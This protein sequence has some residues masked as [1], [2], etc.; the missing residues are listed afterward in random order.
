MA[1][2]TA[3]WAVELKDL[4][5]P[6]ASSGTRALEELR[7]KIDQDTKALRGLQAAQQR[8]KVASLTNAS[9]YTRL[10]NQI[11]AKRA[12][13]GRAEIAFADL[14]GTFD[15]TTDKAA[16][17]TGAST[18]LLD[19]LKGMPG[20]LGSVVSRMQALAGGGGLFALGAAGAIAVAT[21]L[22]A[23]A[24]AAATATARLLAYGI[25]QADA[26]RSELLRLEGL[27][28]IRRYH[29]LAAGSATELQS[30]IDR[31]S[32]SSALGRSEVS[33]YAEQLYRM[34]L[35]GRALSEALEGVA[36]TASVQGDAM[37]R[38]FAGMTAAAVRTGGSVRRLA[39]D[40]RARLGGIARRQAMSLERQM[41]RLREG[42]SAIFSG[43]QIEG[44]LSALNSV[45]SLFSQSTETG[46]ALRTMVSAL[47]N[48]L[49]DQIGA[50]AP[51]IRRFFQGLVIGAQRIVIGI[52]R[53]RN[54]WL[55]TFGAS[56]ILA[57]MDAQNFALHA[58][59]AVMG[60][61]AVSALGAAAAL[62]ALVVV[63]GL[64]VASVLLIAAPFIAVG[65][66]ITAVS[67]AIAL[68]IGRVY[69]SIV[70]TDWA[71]A[72][73]SMAL[74]IARGLEL[75]RD[76]VVKAV[77]SL[78][79]SAT[80]A[81]TETLGIASP[82][83]VFARLGVEIPR[84]LAAGVDRGAPEASAAVED[85]G[86]SAAEAPIGGARGALGGG[87]G[88]S[89]SIGVVNVQTQNDDPRAHAEDFIRQ[90]ADALG[91]VGVQMGATR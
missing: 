18:S 71:D 14:G 25:A 19:R 16:E 64:V 40:V 38:R 90:L 83:R 2:E 75:G 35:R 12:E 85:V 69:E 49:I 22:I 20:P 11:A 29:G 60:L 1:A 15:A 50:A 24:A 37:A 89:V 65:A 6:A 34:G 30:A 8:M 13:I 46:R 61:F 59:I 7:K 44:F 70:S 86:R 57:G 54:W 47:F 4:L 21:A 5:S 27:M 45:T 79:R 41:T 88:V 23:L 55:R 33:G 53:L 73:R 81:L 48:P 66:T 31:V 3:T 56:D 10:K 91:G 78:A 84:G 26:R 39:D 62:G 68:A 43:L 77:R 36:I 17:A 9:A 67:V 72:G 42:V 76:I 52:L 74:G 82:S 63:I 80:E 87:G 58:G 51:L 32:D 28:T